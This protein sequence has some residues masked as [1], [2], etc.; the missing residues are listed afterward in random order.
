[1]VLT[2]TSCGS[3]ATP[4]GAAPS[5]SVQ[6]TASVDARLKYEEQVRAALAQVEADTADP[7]ADW[8]ES[9]VAYQVFGRTVERLQPPSGKVAVHSRI[10][11]LAE[12]AAAAFD[13]A[14]D[15][16]QRDTTNGLRRAAGL[17][18]EPGDDN[19]YRAGP[20]ALEAERELRAT[21]EEL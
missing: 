12:R 18:P 9:A 14:G 1:M 13:E 17:L 4:D 5:S 19:C 11:V 20:D 2:V 8:P 6:T 15:V 10:L 3:E 21:V 16:C 7:E